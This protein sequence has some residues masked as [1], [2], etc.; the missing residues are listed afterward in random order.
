MPIPMMN[1]L[2]GGLHAANN[3]DIQEFM[4]VPVG[5]KCF[6][7]GVRM[8]S[9]VYHT[10]KNIL[11][12]EGLSST[13]G[14]E[15]GFAPL[16]SSDEDAIKVILRAINEMGYIPGKDF[17]IALDV[18]ASEWW[19][20]GGYFMPKRKKHMTS[21]E[22]VSY[23]ETLASSYPILS[24]EDGVGEEDVTVG[25]GLPRTLKEKI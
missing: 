21:D 8:C 11:V 2:N 20:D 7:D 25:R 13:V 3:I 24:I 14:D 23:F 6:S 18:A 17:K 5:A 16:L 1:I 15:G 12:S 4:I 10:L 22:L 9:E 19:S